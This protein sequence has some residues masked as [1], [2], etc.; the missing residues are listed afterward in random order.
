MFVRLEIGGGSFFRT[1]LFSDQGLVRRS[2]VPT[3]PSPPPGRGGSGEGVGRVRGA[4]FIE[5][6]VH[7]RQDPP[8]PPRGRASMQGRGAEVG[9]P[10][11]SVAVSVTAEVVEDCPPP[12]SMGAG[13]RNNSV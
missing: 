5:S 8:L 3:L 2:P 6:P 7:S 12:L 9:E 10:A 1:S 13:H 11:A 4:K